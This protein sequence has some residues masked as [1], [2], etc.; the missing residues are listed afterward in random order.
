[1]NVQAGDETPRLINL[2]SGNAAAWNNAASESLIDSVQIHGRTVPI[3]W[4]LDRTD[5]HVGPK[6]S[7]TAPI[8][9]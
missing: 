1:M 2:R 6:K 7:R 8:V 4:K 5:S 3:H 9:M